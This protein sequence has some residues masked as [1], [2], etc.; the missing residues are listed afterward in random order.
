MTMANT[1]RR[2]QPHVTAGLAHD[3]TEYARSLGY[4]DQMPVIVMDGR[5]EVGEEEHA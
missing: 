1:L 5:I 2:A 4:S 3:A